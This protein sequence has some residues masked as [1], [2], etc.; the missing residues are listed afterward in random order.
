MLALRGTCDYLYVER[1]E[2][3]LQT[4]APERAYPLRMMLSA[5]PDIVDYATPWFGSNLSTFMS[6]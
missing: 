6:N 1:A 5:W 2:P 3:S 4:A